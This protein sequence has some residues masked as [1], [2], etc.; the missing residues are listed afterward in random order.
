MIVIGKSKPLS[1]SVLLK[2][3]IEHA[4]HLVSDFGEEVKLDGA[5]GK[6]LQYDSD[7]FSVLYTTPFSGRESFP[8]KK[9]YCVDIWLNNKKVLN[10]GFT[11][12]EAISET[13]T[14]RSQWA[15]DFLT[16]GK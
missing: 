12:L 9:E 14:K 16:I 13:R 7:G 10:H 1:K 4:I 5:P 3:I 11:S 6:L 15:V 8:G 2:S